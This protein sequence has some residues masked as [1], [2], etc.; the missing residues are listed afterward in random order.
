MKKERKISIPHFDK[1]DFLQPAGNLPTSEEVTQTVTTITN[2]DKTEDLNTPN[3][4][5]TASH[6]G[7]TS[8]KETKNRKPFN[9]MLNVDLSNEL[10]ILAIKKGISTAD[11]IEIA[12]KQLLESERI[13]Y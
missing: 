10:K 5:N 8:K 2:T 4:Q 3:I 13:G 9:T 7:Q 12:V 11:L 6:K 1:T